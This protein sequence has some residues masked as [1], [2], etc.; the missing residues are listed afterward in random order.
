MMAVSVTSVLNRGA[1]PVGWAEEQN[2]KNKF[3]NWLR[4]A[5][6]LH[7]F[8][9]GEKVQGLH[10]C[11]E[12]ISDSLAERVP[13]L[14]VQGDY[15]LCVRLKVGDLV[16]RLGARDPQLFGAGAAHADV[17][18][19]TC[20]LSSGDR[21]DDQSAVISDLSELQVGRGIRL[22]E[23]NVVKSRPRCYVY[24]VTINRLSYFW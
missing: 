21:P 18:T 9:S 2:Q 3:Q 15:V 6:L 8:T 11:S 10:T 20:D 7:C 1:F 17:E 13:F 5:I 23:E 4:S 14:W 12:D 16:L 24:Y 19:M 22:W